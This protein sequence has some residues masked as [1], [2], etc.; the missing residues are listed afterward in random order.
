VSKTSSFEEYLRPV[1]ATVPPQLISPSAFSDIDGV[2]R[3][4]PATLAY[5]T[6]GF[7]CRLAEMAPRADF[8]VLAGAS[9]GRESL[10]GLHPTSTLP[11]RLM[12][13]PIWRRVADFA[14]QWAD[15]SSPL[16]R[17]VDNVWLE[18]DVDGAPP[19]IP[20]PSVFLAPRP[21]GQE[22]A[23]GVAYEPDL[24]GYI[25]TIETVIQ[26]LSGNELA[27]RKLETLSDCFRALSS[28][29]HVFQV[30]LMLSRGAEAV[31]LCINLRSVE[32]I[33][34]YLAG[35]GWPCSE[36]DVLGVLEPIASLVD[37]V[38]LDI[39]VGETVH[40]KIGLECYFDGI[41]QPRTEPRWGVFLDSLVRDGLCTADKRDALL[42]YPGYVD[43]NAEGI[44]W[45]AALR[46]A[47][48]LLG[49]RS[50]STF[51]R[52]LHH[53]KVVYQPG[54]GLEAKA[55]LAVNHHWHTPALRG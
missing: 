35:V 21:S 16:Y 55:Y 2:A 17:A 37:Y 46:R 50:L 15:P 1:A 39:D 40:H 38:C 6:F 41:K 47:S 13:D 48:H 9:C 45:P 12:T 49:G 5:N 8:S 26:L 4:L 43:E 23:K 30:G 19:V 42:S 7:E 31:R 20:I 33:V 52:S 54:E 25:T 36:A 44:P 28:V 11:A 18:F 53:V 10:A 29:E 3:V 27:P 34:E 24:D 51:I 32:G 22:G 14:V